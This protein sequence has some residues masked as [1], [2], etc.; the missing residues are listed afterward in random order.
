M[1]GSILSIFISEYVMSSYAELF[2]SFLLQLANPS[3]LTFPTYLVFPYLRG[4]CEH[5][6]LIGL[7]SQGKSSQDINSLLYYYCLMRHYATN[8]KVAG[9]IPDE[10]ISQIYLILPAALGPGVYSASNRNEYEK[11]K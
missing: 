5:C 8:R 9:S 4:S 11:Q 3:S 1:A 2:P 7:P 6:C 10:V